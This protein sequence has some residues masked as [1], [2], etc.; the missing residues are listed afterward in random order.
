MT[1]CEVQHVAIERRSSRTRQVH[2]I[3]GFI[4]FA[5]YEG[6]LGEFLPVLKA[7]EYTGI[8]RQTVWGKGEVRLMVGR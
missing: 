8:G 4:G 2:P 7:A 5:E 1:R 6:A 3:G